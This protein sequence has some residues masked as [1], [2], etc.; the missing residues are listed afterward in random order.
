MWFLIHALIRHWCSWCLLVKRTISSLKWAFRGHHAE[1]PKQSSEFRASDHYIITYEYPDWNGDISMVVLL[2][3]SLY[4]LTLAPN[5]PCL[6]FRVARQL[7]VPCTI[8]WIWW[9]NYKYLINRIN[10]RHF[11]KF[12]SLHSGCNVFA[13]FNRVSLA[14]LWD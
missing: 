13:F 4:W 7:T 1:Q 8:L 12:E 14:S 11:D 9:R 3:L 2:E 10:D 5:W 6:Y